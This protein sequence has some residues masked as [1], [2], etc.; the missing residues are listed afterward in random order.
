M[1]EQRQGLPDV[2]ARDADRRLVHAQLGGGARVLD[3]QAKH[4]FG[5]MQMMAL[6]DMIQAALMLKYTTAA[7]RGGLSA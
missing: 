7:R 4:M 6:V 3:A 1:D 2:G 5:D